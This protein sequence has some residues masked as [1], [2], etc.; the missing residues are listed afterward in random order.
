MRIIN[1]A[2]G[3]M[4]GMPVVS[5]REIKKVHNEPPANIPV[6][7]VKTMPMCI[8]H[9]YVSDIRAIRNVELRSKVSGF[10]ETINV[11]EGQK[12][13]KG[14][15]LFRI[16]DTEFKTNVAKAKA[17]LNTAEAE[18]QVAEVEYQRV[19]LLTDKNIVSNTELKLA[20]SKFKAAK[21]RTEEA[22][23]DYNIAAHKL[24]YATIC[25]PFD[26]VVDRIPLRAGSLISEGTLIT[27]VSDISSMY[28]Y[29]DISENE[30]LAY[31]RKQ[32]EMANKEDVAATLILSDGE[33]Y[34]QTGKVETVVSEFD[35]N[36]G[37]I[38]FRATFPNPDHL[39]KHKA[40]GKIKLS[41]KVENALIIP[42][43]ATFEVQ[44]KTYVY[45]LDG[46]DVVRM[47]PFEPADRIDEY[48]IVK[49]GLRDGERIVYEGIQDLKDGMK[50]VP[51][52]LSSDSVYSLTTF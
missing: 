52:Q 14:Q 47:K 10:L 28:A 27:S 46:A 31:K 8:N 49:S 5:C 11:D 41:S 43:K 6:V 17:I 33:T 44:D 3:I 24:S 48:Y 22:R 45:V 35:V 32:N 9:F 39:L 4:L 13:R 1:L 18:E 38:S 15:V 23:S 42:Q 51:M 25:A 40:T 21:A 30:Y 37:S 29:F 26:G 7:A 19:K 36:T 34:A 2:A 50:V 12:V 16:N 20:V